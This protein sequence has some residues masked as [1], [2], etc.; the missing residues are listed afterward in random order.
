[1]LYITTD[2]VTF[3]PNNGEVSTSLPFGTYVIRTNPARG[4]WLVKQPHTS[5]ISTIG[6]AEE[7]RLLMDA[8]WEKTDVNCSVMLSGISGNGKTRTAFNVSHDLNLPVIIIA[9]EHPDLIRDIL[10][11]ITSPVMLFFDEF[12]KNY[13][14]DGQIRSSELL[15][16]LDG[17]KTPIRIYNVFTCNEND[18]INQYFFNRPGRILFNFRFGVLSPSE[19]L[20]FIQSQVTIP[21]EERLVEYLKK[22]SNLS[23][24]ICQN[25]IN[26]IQLFQDNYVNALKHLN[27]KVGKLQ[28][29]L[30]IKNEKGI[31]RFIS[32]TNKRD[33]YRATYY[34]TEDDHRYEISTKLELGNIP[35]NDSGE[36]TFKTEELE[37]DNAYCTNLKED[38]DEVD[39]AA[40]TIKKVAA[41]VKSHEF[42]IEQI[43]IPEHFT[44]STNLT[45]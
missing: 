33:S 36:Y 32:A 25:I 1:M 43:F 42:I 15:S 35:F 29:N 31:T 21:D 10:I 27:I 26:T 9:G 38:E 40:Y 6:T 24:D 3:I 5:R 37:I 28:Y 2:E 17:V 18:K 45:F 12:E 23:Y 8:L 19:A 44:V 4:T 39:D 41:F 22:V 14:G 34:F 16:F 11:N 30:S 20:Q 13:D 7:A